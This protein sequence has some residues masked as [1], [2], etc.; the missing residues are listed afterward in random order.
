MAERERKC[1]SVSIE[2]EP[3]LQEWARK[4]V[5]RGDGIVGG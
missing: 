5:G 3:L 4:A 2:N 1:I